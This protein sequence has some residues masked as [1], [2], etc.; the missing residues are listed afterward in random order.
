[1]RRSSLKAPNVQPD[2]Y[3]NVRIWDAG[4]KSEAY[5]QRQLLADPPGVWLCQG[6]LLTMISR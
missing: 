1:M 5:G 2:G 6:R 4:A 3:L